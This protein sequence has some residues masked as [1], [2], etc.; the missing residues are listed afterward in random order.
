M[1]TALVIAMILAGSTATADAAVFYNDTTPTAEI[2]SPGTTSYSFTGPAR[3]GKLSFELAGY[4]TLDGV[5]CCTDTVTVSLNGTELLSAAYN[6]GGGGANQVFYGSPFVTYYK[7]G[8]PAAYNGTANGGLI[9]IALAANF[10]KTNTLTF[11]YTGAAQGLG[12]EAWGINRV[13][14]GVPEP[15]SWALMVGGLGLVGMAARRRRT[16]VAA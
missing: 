8:S 10:A 13:T 14:A 16:T 11:T 9:D 12:D 1:K 7:S 2:A 5:N 6:L 4:G 15:A 3:G